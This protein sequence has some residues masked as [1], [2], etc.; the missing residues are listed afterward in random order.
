[1]P[2]IS[3][4]IRPDEHQTYPADCRAPEQDHLGVAGAVDQSRDI[5]ARRDDADTVQH[6]DLSD[7]LLP[8]AV[9]AEQQRKREGDGP[10]ENGLGGNADAEHRLEERRVLSCSIV[11]SSSVI[12]LLESCAAGNVAMPAFGSACMPPTLPHREH[13]EAR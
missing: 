11:P 8:I 12:L 13:G 7:F 1:L 9:L 3:D 10:G 6:D 5:S 2:S 4:P